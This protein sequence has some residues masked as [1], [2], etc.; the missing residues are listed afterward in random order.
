MRKLFTLK[1]FSVFALMPSS[2]FMKYAITP[3]KPLI[4]G[5]FTVIKYSVVADD[6]SRIK[7]AWS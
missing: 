6:G 1:I 4:D 7:K 2:W 5:N 3:L